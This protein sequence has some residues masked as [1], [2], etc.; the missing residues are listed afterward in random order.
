MPNANDAA[1]FFGI[2]CWD[3]GGRNEDDAAAARCCPAPISG[4]SSWPAAPAGEGDAGLSLLELSPPVEESRICVP[5]AS[6]FPAAAAVVT[7]SCPCT[8]SIGMED[9]PDLV[10]ESDVTDRP[11]RCRRFERGRLCVLHKDTTSLLLKQ[12]LKGYLPVA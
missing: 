4:M 5:A 9:S 12:D 6:G 1:L 8:K 7:G 10:D 11:R 3:G 2:N